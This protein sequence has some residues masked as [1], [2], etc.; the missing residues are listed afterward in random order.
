MRAA[1]LLLSLVTLSASALGQQVSTS[2]AGHA[3]A[4]GVSWP[5]PPVQRYQTIEFDGRAWLGSTWPTGHPVDVLFGIVPPPPGPYVHAFVGFA[6]I[7]APLASP[8]PFPFGDFEDDCELLVDPILP[9]LMTFATTPNVFALRIP[10]GVPLRLRFSIQIAARYSG[11]VGVE[12]FTL[13]NRLDVA[14]Q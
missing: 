11:G 10:A 12:S 7:G 13:S 9:A 2:I 5:G 4:P 14:I 6:L 8:L 1:I 3:C